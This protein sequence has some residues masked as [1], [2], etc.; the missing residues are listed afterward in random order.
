MIAT[1]GALLATSPAFAAPLGGTIDVIHDSDGSW[2]TQAYECTEGGASLTPR[3]MA[4]AGPQRAPFGSSSHRTLIG[5]STVQTELYRTPVYDGT[6]LSDITRLAYSTYAQPKAVESP[7]RALPYLRINVDDD[8]D[9]VRDASLFFYPSNNTDQHA[10]LNNEWQNWDVAGGLVN[11]DG[12][13]GVGGAT[14]LQDYATDHPDSTLVNNNAGQADGG[15]I[16]TIVGCAQGGDTDPF[17]K[18]VYYTDRVIVGQNGDDTLFDFETDTSETDAGTSTV[19]TNEQNKRS[20]VHSAYDD[21]NYLPPR[22]KFVS[23]PATPPLGDGSLRMLLGANPQRVEL[24]RTPRY[25]DRLLRDVRALSY[26]TFQNPV[27]DNITPQQPV[28]MRLTLDN[29]GDSVADQSLFFFPAN[30]VGQGVVAQST[31]QDWD[32]MNGL[33]NIGGDDGAGEAV[34]LTSYL[35]EHPDSQIVNNH[36]DKPNGGG[37]SLMVG[38][39]GDNQKNGRFFIDDIL[40]RT[41]D[42]ATSMVKSGIRYD[43]EK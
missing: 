31:W 11:V 17:T 18:G 25:D 43:L 12:D 34:T 26:S 33:W 22:Q 32:P 13:T 24:F 21:V 3:Q 15:S 37:L 35:V 30:N 39:A 8:G 36:L 40:V 42:A 16:A 29:D 1:G 2:V 20:W 7:D 23:G 10:I 19:V 28:Y 5:Q 14:T 9:D 38:A 27:G 6:L 41:V 4:V